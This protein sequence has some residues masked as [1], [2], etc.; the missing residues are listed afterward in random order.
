MKNTL[1]TV[2]VFAHQAEHRQKK[3][4]IGERGRTPVARVCVMSRA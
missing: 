1:K 2:T 3:S 4:M